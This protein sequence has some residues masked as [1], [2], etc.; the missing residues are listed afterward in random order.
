MANDSNNR[1]SRN[2]IPGGGEPH[3]TNYGRN[4]W[5]SSSQREEENLS[6]DEIEAR[7][8][9]EKKRAKQAEKKKHNIFSSM[10]ADGRGVDKEEEQIAE[11]PTLVNF[12][13]F[14]GRK[15]NPILS[16]NMLLV[17]GNFPIFF[18]FLAMS[19]YFSI[20]TTT[21]YYLVFAPLRG[22]MLYDHSPATSAL[23]TIFSR[24][25][26]VPVLTTTDYVLF[27]LSALVILTFGPV[28]VGV[29]YIVRNLFRG[30]PVFVMQDF[31]DTIKRNFRQAMIY[32]ILDLGIIFLLIFDIIFFN[33]NYGMNFVLDTMLF[34]VWCLALLYYFMRP[35]IYLMI[36]TFDLSIFKM[37]KNAIRFTVLGVKRNFMFLLGTLV[38][39]LLEYVLMYA[40]FPLAV[41]MPFV[42][43]PAMIVTMSVYA[44]YPKIKQY[45][46]DPFYEEMGTEE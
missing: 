10:Y 14:L 40:Y 8:Q 42:I 22:A 41:I 44:A 5:K 12:F 3:P 29:T 43:I 13:K 16:V 7:E 37:F 11:N 27:A 32:G 2:G 17:L 31:F 4:N 45:M 21:P 24:Q 35:Y 15:L 6:L 25:M 18:F 36:V 20:H 39:L 30:K 9:A 28:R 19:G 33:L 23:W 26:E 46:I 1:N 38:L 34:M